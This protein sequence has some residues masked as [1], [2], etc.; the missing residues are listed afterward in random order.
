MSV[1]FLNFPTLFSSTGSNFSVFASSWKMPVCNEYL[2]ASL[3][4][5]WA[6]PSWRKA[7]FGCTYMESVVWFS[8][9][10]SVNSDSVTLSKNV[11]VM[12]TC[13]AFWLVSKLCCYSSAGVAFPISFWALIS[14]LCPKSWFC[15]NS[16]KCI[17]PS[18]SEVSPHLC[19]FWTQGLPHCRL[20]SCMRRGVSLHYFSTPASP[21]PVQRPQT[22][23]MRPACALPCWTQYPHEGNES[24]GHTAFR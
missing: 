20:Q 3:C 16:L 14:I 12:C 1:F 11:L 21:H 23:C 13:E 8:A 2:F 5:C 9:R 6:L 15:S 24:H 17:L 18:F 7:I 22:A 19:G 10:L 4:V